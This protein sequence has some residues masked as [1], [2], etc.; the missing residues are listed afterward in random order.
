MQSLSQEDIVKNQLIFKLFGQEVGPLVMKKYPILQRHQFIQ[1]LSKIWKELPATEKN[2][3]VFKAD[4]LQMNGSTVP[5]SAKPLQL[6]SDG[7]S[8]STFSTAAQPIQ[9]QT[10]FGKYSQVKKPELQKKYPYLNKTELDHLTVRMWSKLTDNEK[11]KYGLAPPVNRI[12]PLPPA[13]VQNKT[14]PVV[15][16]M[17]EPNEI[18]VETLD[19]FIDQV[20][21]K[22]V[23]KKTENL[24]IRDSDSEDDDDDDDDDV[25]SEM[26]PILVPKAEPL[27]AEEETTGIAENDENVNK[28]GN[29]N[30]NNESETSDDQPLSE[31]LLEDS[32]ILLNDSST[33][34]ENDMISVKETIKTNEG[35]DEEP[36]EN[37]EDEGEDVDNEID[38]V[39]KNCNEDG[40][41]D[42]DDINEDHTNEERP[43]NYLPSNNSANTIISETIS[44][45][46]EKLHEDSPTVQDQVGD[47]KEN[48]ASY[49]VLK[50]K[51]KVFKPLPGPVVLCYCESSNSDDVIGC[52]TCPQWYHPTCINLSD[53][54]LAN[55]HKLDT[56]KCPEC[57]KMSEEF[58]KSPAKTI[59]PPGP[60]NASP[61]KIS[62]PNDNAPVIKIIKP[63][64]A[65]KQISNNGK[66]TTCKVLVEEVKRRGEMI[67]SLKATIAQLMAKKESNEAEEND[68]IINEEEN[69]DSDDNDS[70]S[71][72]IEA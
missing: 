36:K 22:V 55:A 11:Q 1:I 42:E 9:A 68:S 28:E 38:D 67:D 72:N 45:T 63:D 25:I 31:K 62:K 51:R 4:F 49:S 61:V 57:V 50:S 52:D 20:K 24:F 21:V 64:S 46:M 26:H 65:P 69:D 2:K 48:E 43:T 34:T 66:C 23:E 14:L 58:Y 39:P 3:Y 16:N 27:E 17:I 30:F 19:E 10:P 70:D 53:E 60:N 8:K 13:P 40:E 15:Q 32:L 59:E 37:N 18:K 7:V 29:K 12:L 56:W 71:E 33:T 5:K 35:I 6:F 44:E 47:D 41:E 54:Q